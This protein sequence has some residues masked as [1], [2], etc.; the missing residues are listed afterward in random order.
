MG[1]RCYICIANNKGLDYAKLF[2]GTITVFSMCSLVR[3]D[4]AE[5]KQRLFRPSYAVDF[6]TSGTLLSGRFPAL[7]AQS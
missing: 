4:D 6:G 5:N 1:Y 2:R 7:F 3:L